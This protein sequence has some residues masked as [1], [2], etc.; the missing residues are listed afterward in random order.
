MNLTNF[1]SNF[2]DGG[3]RSNLFEVS[4]TKPSG[5]KP[6]PVDPKGDTKKFFCKA[7]NFPTSTINAIDVFYQGRTIKVAGTRPAYTDWTVTI[8]NDE[9]FT[10]R[11]ELEEW[12][13]FMNHHELNVRG[14]IGLPEYKID[15]ATIT[16]FSKD[17]SS[18]GM[19]KFY[20]MFPITIGEI[21]ADWETDTIQTYDVTFALD[22]FEP[23]D[24]KGGAGYKPSN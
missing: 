22:W 2:N 15:S 6:V 12:F 4:W 16:S 18:K 7:S 19:Y 17:G 5:G 23:F 8:M 3:A 1:K 9:D 13:T 24:G 14:K 10:I 21:T 20:G 11:K